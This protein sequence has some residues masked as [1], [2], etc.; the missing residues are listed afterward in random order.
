MSITRRGFLQALTAIPAAGVLLKTAPIMAA[1]DPIKEIRRIAHEIAA[2][3]KIITDSYY[4]QGVTSAHLNNEDEYVEMHVV[5]PKKRRH[6]IQTLTIKTLVAIPDELGIATREE[7]AWRFRVGGWE[8]ILAVGHVTRAMSMVSHSE[9][10][11]ATNPDGSINYLAPEVRIPVIHYEYEMIC[12]H[13][14]SG[15][16][17]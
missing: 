16:I 3:K 2:P 6:V 1:P 5:N 14:S 4:L 10:V 11:P 13:I 15:A 7:V 8:N 12:S 9:M 17:T